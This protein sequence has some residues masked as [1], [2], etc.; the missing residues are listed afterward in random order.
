[1]YYRTKVPADALKQLHVR[2]D[3]QGWARC[4]GHAFILLILGGCFVVASN[5]GWLLL[6][7][8]LLAV[9]GVVFSFLSWVGASHELQHNT[10]SQSKALNQCWLQVFAF[11]S[12]ANPVYFTRAHA[13]HHSHT[14]DSHLDEE[15]RTNVCSRIAN[16]VL[17]ST[18]DIR[19]FWRTLRMQ[20]LNARGIVPGQTEGRIF[21]DAEVDGRRRLANA[22]RRLLVGQAA[23]LVLFLA[24]GFWQGVFLVTLGPFIANGFAN[25][26][27][28]AQHCG[29]KHNTLDYRESTRT[30][31]LS[32][33]LSFLY[34]NMNYHVEHH[35]YP[36]VP[37]YNLPKLHELIAYDVAPPARGLRGAL[38]VIRK[39]NRS[40]A[41]GDCS[42]N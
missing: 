22:A 20:V 36:G 19:R 1:M 27:A 40:R 39:D 24:S 28:T 7:A 12:W 31:L 2:N 13:T 9:Y 11:L 34:W 42:L 18:I 37:C 41:V 32:P 21:S 17:S 25:M 16:L 5:N 35:M 38:K 29:M 30:I 26:L 15:V 4:F 14:L 3:L 8:V 6:A 33:F 23:L 10:V